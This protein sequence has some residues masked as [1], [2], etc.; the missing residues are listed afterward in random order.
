MSKS[1]GSIDGD[2]RSLTKAM[3]GKHPPA[4]LLH[5]NSRRARRMAERAAQRKKE[6]ANRW[7]STRLEVKAH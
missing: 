3:M 7:T 4:R 2:Y 1:K 6:R 5:P